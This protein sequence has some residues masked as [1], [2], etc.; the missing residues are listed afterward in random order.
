M[1]SKQFSRFAGPVV[2]A[3][4]LAIGSASVASAATL[5]DPPGFYN[6]SGQ[7][8]TGFTITQT[9]TAELGLGVLYRYGSAVQPAANTNVYNV[10]VGY[11]PSTTYALW[12]IQY[13]VNLQAF[14]STDVLNDY[15]Y[16]LTIS[17]THG[18]S[19]SFDPLA[20]FTDNAGW[21]GSKNVA[22]NGNEGTDWGFQNSENLAFGEFAGLNFNPL[23]NETYL[24]T[25]SLTPIVSGFAPLVA[26]PSVSIEIN[27]TPI[28]AALPLFGSGL[29]LMGFLGWRKKRKRAAASP[30]CA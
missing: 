29:G 24:V 2:M 1:P 10:D 18:N 28:P 22:N 9:D 25:L 5:V 7:P 17:D 23:A 30:I 6:G 21:N 3:A 14:G 8:N 20:M 13:S 27:A 26:S 4:L 19:V 12:N 16:N 15:T 11:Y